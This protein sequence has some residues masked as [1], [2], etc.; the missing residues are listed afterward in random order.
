MEPTDYPAPVEASEDAL[1]GMSAPSEPIDRTTR[2]FLKV[3]LGVL[4][5]AAV[6]LV[7]LLSIMLRPDSGPS[8]VSPRLVGKSPLDV[9]KVIFT[10][11][12]DGPLKTPLGVAF[13]ADGGIWIADTGNSRVAVFTASGKFVALVGDQDG[14]GK[15]YAPYGLTVDSANDRAYVADYTAGAVRVYTTSGRYVES[16]P[17]SEQSLD[18]FGPN[19]FTPFE[20]KVV[21]NKIVVASNDGLYFFSR[22]GVVTARWGGASRGSAPGSFNFPDAFDYDPALKRYYVADTLNRRVKALDADGKVLWTSGRP[23]AAGKIVG[24]W[25]LPRGITVGAEGNLFVVDTFRFDETGVGAGFFVV[26]SKDGKLLSEFGRVGT[27]DD[28]FSFPEK[29]AVG[30]AGVMAVADRENHRVVLFTVKTLP[31]PTER[32]RSSYDSPRD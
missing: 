4:T 1:G 20:V 11:G 9:V 12:K 29:I 2:R 3:M 18:V 30:S 15:L 6:G 25:Q 26:L 32:E 16:I 28:A 14:P 19:G 24:F 7:I 21:G 27:E 31:V 5:A 22:R 8:V 23:D 17:S 13:D 10:T